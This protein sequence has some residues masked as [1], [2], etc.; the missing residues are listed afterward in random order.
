MTGGVVCLDDTVLSLIDDE[1]GVRHVT[2]EVLVL[3]PVIPGLAFGRFQA[4]ICRLSHSTSSFS[5]LG[6]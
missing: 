4:H 6:D 3:I 5:W 2:D 1:Y